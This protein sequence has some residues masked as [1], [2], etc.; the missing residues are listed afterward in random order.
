M[1]KFIS[2]GGNTGVWYLRASRVFFSEQGI[3]NPRFDICIYIYIYIYI[4]VYICIYIHI[5]AYYTYIA[6]DTHITYIHTPI[7]SNTT[8]FE[9]HVDLQVCDK[10]MLYNC[11][12]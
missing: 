8:A 5:H 12:E 4:C 2:P 3:A 10:R 1:F 9:K 7:D 6:Y 11:T